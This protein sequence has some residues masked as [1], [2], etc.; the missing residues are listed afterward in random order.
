MKQLSFS[1][2]IYLV[3]CVCFHNSI[4]SQTTSHNLNEQVYIVKMRTTMGKIEFR[5]YNE[6]PLHRDNF[7]KLVTLG[8]YNGILFHRVINNFVIQGGDPNSKTAT[9]NQ[10]LGEHSFGKNIPAEIRTDVGLR[11]HKGSVIAA[12]ESD[13]VNPFHESSASQFCFIMC[14]APHLDGGYTIFGEVTTGMNVLEKMQC[15]RT[16]QFDRPIDDI[17]ILSARIKRKKCIK[18]VTLAKRNK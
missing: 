7:V 3:T 16:D 6:T 11:H 13:D 17:R 2:F 1:I 4:M 5:L 9:K 10:R 12:R 18:P 8:F 15:V 14:D